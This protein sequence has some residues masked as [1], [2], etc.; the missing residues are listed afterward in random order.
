M[1]TQE[2]KLADLYQELANT[3][4]GYLEHLSATYGWTRQTSP[5]PLDAD[6]SKWRVVKPVKTWKPKNY[7]WDGCYEPISIVDI[8][9]GGQYEFDSEFTR[10]TN[11]QCDELTQLLRMTAFIHAYKCEFGSDGTSFVYKDTISNKWNSACEPDMFHPDVVYMDYE[12]A[13][14][15]ASELNSGQVILPKRGIL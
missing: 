11:E 13:E 6:L 4:N 5:P 2:Q 9:E 12:C 14:K 10:K 15:L 8:S 1:K 7:P 3:D